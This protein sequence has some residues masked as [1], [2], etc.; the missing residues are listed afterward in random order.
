MSSGSDSA[1]S[2]VHD[3][4]RQGFGA[5]G[6][7]TF[8]EM[9]DGDGSSERAKFPCFNKCRRRNGNFRLDHGR[10]SL[11]ITCREWGE[12][13]II[14]SSLSACVFIFSFWASLSFYRFTYLSAVIY[15]LLCICSC[16]SRSTLSLSDMNSCRL[17]QCRLDTLTQTLTLGVSSAADFQM[18]ISLNRSRA[19]HLNFDGG[20]V[21][22]QLVGRNSGDDK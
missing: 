13:G 8:S 7:V 9:A 15:L 17:R 20:V 2:V 5:I 10:F 21:V 1:S 19:L 3:T 18:Y 4:Q 12:T 11:C 16:L 14:S 22:A 6:G